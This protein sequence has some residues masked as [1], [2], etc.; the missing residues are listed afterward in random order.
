MQ[1]SEQVSNFYTL[2]REYWGELTGF[3][4]TTSSDMLN[5][6]Y[7]PEGIQNLHDAQNAFI[8]KIVSQIPQP[9]AEFHGLEVG[10]GI[11]GV[12]IAVLERLRYSRLMGIDI[13]P[14]QLALAAKNAVARGV[15]D[16]LKCLLGDA[17]SLPI[18][19][20]SAD[21]SLCI[22]S[23]F[24]YENKSLFL[25]EFFR[26]LKPGG[27]A[28][29]ADI[30]CENNDSV[31]FRQGNHFESVDEYRRLVQKAGF[32]LLKVENIGPHV[33]KPLYAHIV[34]FNRLSRSQVSKY[35]SLV[36][37]NYC[38]LSN[39]GDMGYHIFTLHRPAVSELAAGD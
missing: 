4:A 9:S 25:K 16:R 5:F 36:L 15:D 39:T 19:D 18:G 13:S 38:H 28:V 2:I 27:T 24:H 12:S 31:R 20:N 33:Y 32:K 35:W 26:T 8:D 1:S 30:T 14:D 23:S 3:N 10:C 17:M 21:F 37:S 11:G 7:W 34:A 6:G 22:E 29:L